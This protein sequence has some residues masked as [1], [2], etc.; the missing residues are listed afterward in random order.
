MAQLVIH[1]ATLRCTFGVAPSALIV[2]ATSMVNGSTMP[3]ATI[4]DFAPLVNIMPFGMCSA[5]S[6]PQVIAAQGAPVPC[7]PVTTT[8]WKPPSPT[9]MVGKKNALNNT[10]TCMCNWLGVITVNQPGQGTVNVP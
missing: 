6:N 2:M 7:V 4:M 8:P 10:A 9:V 5:P 3:V 1:G